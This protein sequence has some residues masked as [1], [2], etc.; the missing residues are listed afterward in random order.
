[1]EIIEAA[2]RY[3]YWIGFKFVPWGDVIETGA[4]NIIIV[5]K[6]FITCLKKA[7]FMNQ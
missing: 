6:N 3:W 2:W 7:T 1:M 5:K 4:T